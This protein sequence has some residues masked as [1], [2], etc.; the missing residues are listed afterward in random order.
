MSLSTTNMLSN[1]SMKSSNMLKETWNILNSFK[2][3]LLKHGI[4]IKPSLNLFFFEFEFDKTKINKDSIIVKHNIKNCRIICESCYLYG[5]QISLNH[6]N[7]NVNYTTEIEHYREKVIYDKFIIKRILICLFELIGINIYDEEITKEKC[8]DFKT[9]IHN[10]KEHEHFEEYKENLKNLKSTKILM[11]QNDKTMRTLKKQFDETS[12]KINKIINE[13][14][15]KRKYIKYIQIE[16]K[17]VFNEIKTVERSVHH[18]L[19]RYD[20]EIKDI[21]KLDRSEETKNKAITPLIAE[22][23]SYINLL[24]VLEKDFKYKEE[25]IIKSKQDKEKEI[26]IKIINTYKSK[27][28]NLVDL[29]KLLYEKF[30][31]E[32]MNFEKILFPKIFKFN[33]EK[34]EEKIEITEYKRKYIK[35]LKKINFFVKH[36]NYYE[37]CEYEINS[38]SKKFL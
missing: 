36:F 29:N 33:T 22:K 5:L 27:F 18:I 28:S 32:N 13:E 1:P 8:K 31:I 23:L 9:I 4:I 37:D 15:E 6:N 19:K 14:E 26:L 3:D 20:E 7:N 24:N 10:I 25:D 16:S 34:F 11:K 21:E 2:D 35:I 38:Y 17:S 12:K 30:M